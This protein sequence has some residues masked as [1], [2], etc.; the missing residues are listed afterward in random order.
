M[1]GLTNREHQREQPANAVVGERA[2][3][4]REAQET[5]DPSHRDL[6]CSPGALS[7]P[8]A[9]P[10]PAPKQTVLIS[11]RFRISLASAKPCLFLLLRTGSAVLL[12][13]RRCAVQ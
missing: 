7:Q 1:L 5:L 3:R 2:A 12:H 8:I 9:A 10:L 11:G 13:Q 6:S 4:P